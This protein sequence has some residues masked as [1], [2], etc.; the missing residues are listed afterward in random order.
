M[1]KMR[2]RTETCSYCHMRRGVTVN[3]ETKE[4]V[5]VEM[6]MV[7]CLYGQKCVEEMR[8]KA[9]LAPFEDGKVRLR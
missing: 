6:P 5:S 1:P 4:V 3:L 9:L 2:N 8:D 7:N